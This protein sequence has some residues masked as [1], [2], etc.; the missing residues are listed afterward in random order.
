MQPAL[1]FPS[2]PCGLRLL[3]ARRSSSEGG[4][5][6]QIRRRAHG[7]CRVGFLEPAQAS[8]L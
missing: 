7:S 4:S 6:R 5:A 1:L 3:P 2:S 8:S